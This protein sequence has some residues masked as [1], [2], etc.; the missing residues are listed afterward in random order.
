MKEIPDMNNQ[1]DTFCLFGNDIKTPGKIISSTK[2]ECVSPPSYD[3]RFYLLEI[4][5]NNREYTDDKVKFFYY[6]PPFVYSINPKIGP[7]AG[8]TTVK[9]TGSNFEDTGYVM[10]KFGEKIVTGT[11]VDQNEILCVAPQ[12][13]K[14]AKVNLALAIRPDEFSSGINTIYRYYDTPIIDSISP[15]CGPERGFTQITV[16]GKKFPKDDSEYIKC[17]FDR[18]IFK[19]ITV[20]DENTLK[21][22]SPSVLDEN[23]ENAKNVDFYLLE[24][25]LNGIDISG[26]AQ[27]FY[28]Y[29][30]SFIQN[31]EPK[32]GPLSGNTLISLNATNINHKN[33][34]NPTVRF[35]TVDSLPEKINKLEN[36]LL[37]KSPPGFYSGAVEVQISL[38]GQ[39]YEPDT[40]VNFRDFAHTFYYYNFP[41]VTDVIPNGGP[42]TGKTKISILGL[43]FNSPFYFV[44]NED[45]KI[46]NYRFVDSKDENIV[47]GETRSTKAD[48]N[49]YLEIISPI[50]M[51]DKLS[52]KI[53]LSYNKQN[54][55][56]I[57]NEEFIFFLLPNITHISPS[58]GP[59]ELKEK[60]IKIHLD[61]YYCTKNCDSILCKYISKNLKYVERGSY[62]SPNLINCELPYVNSPGN[63]EVEVSFNNVEHYTN[64]KHTYTF[65]KPYVQIVEPQ[66]IPS[67]GN[68]KL[69]I[70]GYGFAD[71]KENLKVK[72]GDKDIKCSETPN[73]INIDSQDCIKNA[74]FINENTIE[75]QTFPRSKMYKI[76]SKK[77]IEYER[78]P[79]EVSVFNDDFTQNNST[80]FFMDEPK[81][82][83]DFN[84]PDFIGSKELIENIKQNEIKS[85]PANIDTFILLPVNSEKIKFQFENFEQFAKY[86]C[87]FEKKDNPE[88]RKITDGLISSLPK[89]KNSKNIFFCQSPEWENLGL[90]NIKI[91]LNGIDFSE[92]YKEIIFTDPLNILHM[93]PKS[94][95]LDGNTEVEIYGTGFDNDKDMQFKWGIFTVKPFTENNFL[96]NYVYDN[97]NNKITPKWISEHKS[98]YPI[99]QIKVKS[100]KGISNMRECGGPEYIVLTKA[101][102]INYYNFINELIDN[103]SNKNSLKSSSKPYEYIHSNSEFYY[104]RQPYL[105]AIHPKG[106]IITGGVEVIVFGA[107]FKNLPENG[108]RP[109][110]KFGDIIVLGKFISTVR[111]S[112][113]SPEYNKGNVKVPFE[114]SLNKRDFTKS[115]LQFTYYNDFK[116]AKFNLI[117]PES[118]PN[119]GGTHINI[120]GKNFTNLLDPEEFLCKFESDDKKVLPKLV[121]AGFKSNAK[122][123]EDAIICNSPGGWK[124]GTKAKISI[125]FDGQTFTSTGFYFYFYKVD[126]VYP[127]SGPN[128]GNGKF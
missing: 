34:C 24:L 30:E 52:T 70:K 61:N 89:K 93:E 102:E 114:V 51:K 60:N 123:G 17:V 11:Y 64:N 42:T 83:S 33:A 56:T 67:K 75:V 41:I 74:R 29:K 57:P 37:I 49:S 81:I 16:K 50:V 22:D 44:E 106:S 27:N 10:C 119:T 68:S 96:K 3:N 65:Y 107:W 78:F 55:E 118:G 13:E 9:I 39:D 26:P 99:K 63:Y 88:I 2:M 43:N 19:N 73:N 124:S 47:Y 120:Y 6:H 25:S 18:K 38:N 35:S 95:P 115:G 103:N 87:L 28:Y 127:L 46:I 108:V 20:I 77:N 40:K 84:D 121:P 91:S 122:E 101:N 71:S 48:K 53:Q 12:V 58:Y 31:I 110:C 113:I 54:F 100:P 97:N 5:L 62:I 36:N 23:G 82:I 45:D 15:S 117:E 32:F 4:T 104:Y 86:S 112:C 128:T 69:I 1:N 59:V 90:F 98:K 109:Y 80:V 7:T 66:M 116:Y 14:P 92:T 105:Q 111:I 94:G 21:C 79:I 76:S 125:T 72:F 85:L 126:K 8:G